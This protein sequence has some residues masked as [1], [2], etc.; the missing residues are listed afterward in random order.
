MFMILNVPNEG[1]PKLHVSGAPKSDLP[2]PLGVQV[3]FRFF[4]SL[5]GFF[6]P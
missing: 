3:T 2:L 5:A 1:A 4:C 6:Q